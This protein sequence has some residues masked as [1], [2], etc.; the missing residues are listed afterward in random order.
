MTEGVCHGPNRITTGSHG[1]PRRGGDEGAMG[2]VRESGAWV[3]TPGKSAN[4][5]GWPIRN[6]YSVL[7][8]GA[9]WLGKRGMI[10]R[11]CRF[12]VACHLF[13]FSAGFFL[14]LH[15]HDRRLG[16]AMF[17]LA[18]GPRQPRA[19]AHTCPQARTQQRNIPARQLSESKIQLSPHLSSPLCPRDT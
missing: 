3:K 15:D 2:I 4:R 5:T 6:R 1:G 17:V 18:L 11:W 12:I 19:L 13:I 16:E 10:A 8:G 7:A 14:L 9:G